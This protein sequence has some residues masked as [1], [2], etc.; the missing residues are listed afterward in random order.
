MKTIL[1]QLFCICGLMMVMMLL[2]KPLEATQEMAKAM[3]KTC[4]GCHSSPKGGEPGKPNLNNFG[5]RYLT[6]IIRKEAYV[7]LNPYRQ[8]NHLAKE[9]ADNKRKAAEKKEEEKKK[10]ELLAAAATQETTATADSQSGEAAQS[11]KSPDQPADPTAQK[12]VSTGSDKPAVAAQGGAEGT[13]S[14]KPVGRPLVP[15]VNEEA[16]GGATPTA[17]SPDPTDNK[18]AN[19]PSFFSRSVTRPVVS[20]NEKPESAKKTEAAKPAEDLQV[21]P[22]D[23]IRFKG[24]KTFIL[25]KQPKVVDVNYD[26]EDDWEFDDYH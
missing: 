6:N 9:I 12:P 21:K 4:T 19:A 25:K 20:Q 8:L 3:R 18:S 16:K 7:P 5:M 10:E 24:G 15:K 26:W 2:I 17:S 23:G 1:N 13:S 14:S 11:E 22:G